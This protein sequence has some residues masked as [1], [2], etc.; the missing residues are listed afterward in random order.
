MHLK[1]LWL[2]KGGSLLAI[3]NICFPSLCANKE[4]SLHVPHCIIS[5]LFSGQNPFISSLLQHVLS[6]TY[7]HVLSSQVLCGCVNILQEIINKGIDVDAKNGN[8]KVPSI[9]HVKIIMMELYYSWYSIS[10]LLLPT[11]FFGFKNHDLYKFV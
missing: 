11:F 4:D 3:W 2:K 1:I 10:S 8:E 7:E 9:Q 6:L 5:L